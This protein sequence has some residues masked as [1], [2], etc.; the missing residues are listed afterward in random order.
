MS[1][2]AP[3]QARNPG[4]SWGYRFLRITDRV[5]PEVVYRPL[6]AIGT[7]I[8]LTGMPEQRRHSREYLAVI[9]GRP[10]TLGEVFRHFFS[11][12]EALMQRLRIANGKQIECEYTPGSDD[13]R[14]WMENGGPVLLGSMH[15]GVSDMLGFQLAGK[16]NNT[17]YLV[18]QR[19]G[20]SH[21]TEALARR[22]G[23]AL[24]FIWVNDP[25]EMLY[26]LKEALGTTGA[27]AIQCDRV[28]PGSRT[29]AFEFLGMRRLFPFT[30]YHLA[31]L[32][33]RPVLL[34]FGT[35]GL[36]G[37]S[38]LHAAPLFMRVPGESKDAA[39]E[40][41]R[42]HFQNFLYLLEAQL[43]LHPFLW[44]NFLPLNPVAGESPSAI[45]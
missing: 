7:W 20:N 33:D 42:A 8:A 15:V 1:N 13:F 16:S 44:F 28:E 38:Q 39:L 18:R 35:P 9:L 14:H 27:V 25:G 6:R 5:L 2:P 11:F 12:E 43:R 40:R 10:P 37:R 30:I 17:I 31:L 3:T 45:K 21:D 34:S 22:F 29:E 23:P 24:R 26:A 32:F 41:A 19:V 4:P 36:N